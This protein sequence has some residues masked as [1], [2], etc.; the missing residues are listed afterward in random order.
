[1][2]PACNHAVQPACGEHEKRQLGQGC[3]CAQ[4]TALFFILKQDSKHLNFDLSANSAWVHVE[5]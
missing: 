1:M 3:K 2:Q 5:F 4:A